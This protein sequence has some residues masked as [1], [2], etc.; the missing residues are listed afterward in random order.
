MN[1]TIEDTVSPLLVISLSN[2]HYIELNQKETPKQILEVI[3]P[4]QI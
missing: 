3:S 4:F 2:S 1:I